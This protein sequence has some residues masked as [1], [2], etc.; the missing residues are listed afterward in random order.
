MMLGGAGFLAMTRIVR[1]LAE[2]LC[3]GRLVFVLEGGYAASGLVDGTRALLAGLLEAAP[4]RP[5]AVEAPPG[6]TLR[7]LVADVAAV[8]GGRYPGLGAA[9]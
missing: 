4:Q 9:D 5:S 7:P 2:E 1:A 6:S 3:E 8:H